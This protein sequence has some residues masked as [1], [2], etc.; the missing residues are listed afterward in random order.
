MQI[1]YIFSVC[2]TSSVVL[3]RRI[4]VSCYVV[5]RAG[6]T[7]KMHPILRHSRRLSSSLLFC[8]AGIEL[9]ASDVLT[10]LLTV[11]APGAINHPP[12][13]LFE[14]EICKVIVPPGGRERT[15][16]R[17]MSLRIVLS[18]EW[19][20]SQSAAFRPQKKQG[21]METNFPCHKTR[22][23]CTSLNCDEVDTPGTR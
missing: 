20:K 19:T 1:L 9:H 16:L 21:S 22:N 10:G 11:R 8:L 23:A 6:T 12:S 3:R 15:S 2:F 14:P 7:V 18:I 5:A 4:L 17:D 13:T